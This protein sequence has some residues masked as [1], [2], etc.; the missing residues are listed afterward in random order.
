MKTFKTISAQGEIYIRRIGAVPM[1]PALPDGFTAMSVKNGKFVIGES[2]THHDHCVNADHVSVGVMDRPPAGMRILRMI[3]EN[4]TALTHERVHDT[5]DPI[6]LEP[7]E[8]EVRIQREF[9]PYAEL[10]RQVAD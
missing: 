1:S 7:G 9:D 10:A 5:H 4:P 3:V 8:Y 6:M 2:E